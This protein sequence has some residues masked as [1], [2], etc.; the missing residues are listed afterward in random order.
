LWNLAGVN[1]LCE[2]LRDGYSY[3]GGRFNQ[4][5][6]AESRPFWLN[7]VTA[8]YDSSAELW[9]VRSAKIAAARD[10]WNQ[11][12]TLPAPQEI[13]IPPVTPE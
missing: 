11:R 8:R 10:Q 13:G 1:G 4:V 6:L 5:W 9:A 3:L 7:I 2:D 12:H